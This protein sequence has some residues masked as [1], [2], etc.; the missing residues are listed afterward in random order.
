[1][2]I[3]P[4]FPALAKCQH[5]ATVSSEFSTFLA[6]D[7]NIEHR[8]SFVFYTLN[9]NPFKFR[10]STIP[11]PNSRH[12]EYF[13]FGN[14]SI[15]SMSNAHLKK[16]VRNKSDCCLSVLDISFNSTTLHTADGDQQSDVAFD[17]YEDEPNKFTIQFK[18]GNVFTLKC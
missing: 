2:C 10:M 8:E 17:F 6:L 12:S 3:L 15:E 11:I 9:A 4:L 18:D 14:L 1:M 16:S 7:E 5:I 13:N